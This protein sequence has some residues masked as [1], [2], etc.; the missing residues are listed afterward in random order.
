MRS[1][2]SE[3]SIPPLTKDKRAQ[4]VKLAKDYAEKS[5]ATACA[6]DLPS[7]SLHGT[8]WERWQSGTSGSRR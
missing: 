3:V 8:L 1:F 5:K 6:N 2:D 7:E 4:Y